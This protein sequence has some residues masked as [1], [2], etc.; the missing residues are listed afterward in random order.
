MCSG[1]KLCFHSR[2]VYGSCSWIL[3]VYLSL[4]L[5][6]RESKEASD[7]VVTNLCPPSRVFFTETL[8]ELLELLHV[9]RGLVGVKAR[10]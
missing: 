7:D 6:V 2:A 9:A 10:G 1:A 3:Q 5:G 4:D 8:V